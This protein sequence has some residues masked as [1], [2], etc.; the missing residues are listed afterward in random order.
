MA[1]YLVGISGLLKNNK[2]NIRNKLG[3][4]YSKDNNNT[5]SLSEFVNNYK[6]NKKK[7][8]WFC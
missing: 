2:E 3:I 4:T 1:N 6:E 8:G 7:N 5:D